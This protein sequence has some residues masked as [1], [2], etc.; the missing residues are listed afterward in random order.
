MKDVDI[1][2]IG[3]GYVGQ[4][5]HK[6]FPN[7]WIYDPYILQKDF[8]NTRFISKQM[9]SMCK[10][11][12]ICVPTPTAK[13]GWSCDTSIV[14]GLFKWL[15][16][17]LVLIKSTVAPGTTKKLQKKYKYG[18]ICM[19]P[20]YIGMGSYFIPTHYP[21]PKNP[22]GHGFMIIGGERQWGFG[23]VITHGIDSEEWGFEPEHFEKTGEKLELPKEPR[24]VIV[25]SPAGM[26]KAY[27][28]I[29]GRQV[30][31]KV[32]DAGVEMVWVGVNKKFNSFNDYRDYLGRSLVFFSPTWQSPRP[33]SRLEAM[34]SKC[35]IVTTPYHDADSF[36]EEGYN[37]FLTSKEPIQDPRV[38]DNPDYSAQLIIDLVHNRVEEAI[39]VGKNAK[40]TA[41]KLFNKKHFDQQWEALLKKHGVL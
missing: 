41:T 21:D 33:R 23:E 13:D 2:I 10:L 16:A 37:G 3:Y 30:F 15:K 8:P 24:C 34:H 18:G 14:E 32:E 20:E 12:I 6:V 40:L 22:T 5:Y 1:V 39:E 11:A 38:M 29:F 31:R 27:R 35:C 4:A 28:R 26:E 19:S 36:I 7:A 9:V 17:P 25:L